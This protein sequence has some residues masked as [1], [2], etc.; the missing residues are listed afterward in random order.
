M[1]GQ[2]KKGDAFAIFLTIFLSSIDTSYF[3]KTIDKV[4]EMLHDIVEKVGESNVVQ[5]I[6]NNAANYKAMG[7][8]LM[9]CKY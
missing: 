5:V 7:E 6:T 3:S 1:V 8:M 4:F 9:S 2:T